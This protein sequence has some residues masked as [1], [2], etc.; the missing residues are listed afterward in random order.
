MGGARAI[1]A[2]NGR[3]VATAGSATSAA[4][5]ASLAG[6]GHDHVVETLDRRRQRSSPVGEVGFAD[7][8][9]GAGV[10]EHE[11]HLG[12]GPLGVRR[13]HRE[14]EG[15]AR[16]R[17]LDVLGPVPHPRGDPLAH[18]QAER[19][20][21]RVPEADAAVGQLGVGP[22]PVE[23]GDDGQEVGALVGVRGTRS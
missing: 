5:R 11:A 17:G 6:A 9:P 20:V 10:L 21:Q 3:N 7:Q 13:H 15:A 4:R 8:D 19:V 22:H 2:S 14:P 16:Q 1:T 18:R 23:L 12:V